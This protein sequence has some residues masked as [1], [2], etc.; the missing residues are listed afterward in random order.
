MSDGNLDGGP[1]TDDSESSESLKNILYCSGFNKRE[2]NFCEESQVSSA[3]PY[4]LE[5]R[6]M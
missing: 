1:D 6:F 3:E 5:N 2:G 4:Q